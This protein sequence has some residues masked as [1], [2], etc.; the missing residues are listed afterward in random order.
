VRVV[1]WGLQTDKR[2][3]AR[4]DLQQTAAFIEESGLTI[5]AIE[6]EYEE[7]SHV[8]FKKKKQLTLTW[9][10]FGKVRMAQNSLRMLST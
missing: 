6:K 10:G 2:Y 9:T 4:E 8:R 7:Y 3:G 1:L 5:S